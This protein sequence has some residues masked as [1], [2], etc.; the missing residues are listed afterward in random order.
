MF[1]MCKYLVYLK[2]KS[3]S[4]SK[5]DIYRHFEGEWID[6]TLGVRISHS[7]SQCYFCCSQVNVME[8]LG[9]SHLG[10]NWQVW[11]ENRWT[12]DR[13]NKWNQWT[14]KKKTE[15]F[16]AF[17][18]SFSKVKYYIASTNTSIWR[19]LTQSVL[20]VYVAEKRNQSLVEL[21]TIGTCMELLTGDQ[22]DIVLFWGNK[23]KLSV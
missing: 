19:I 2:E 8:W 14:E 23:S 18:R 15:D 16:Y 7:D 21:V 1:C 5:A 4:S 6:M 22:V 11:R 3:N 12:N 9:K 17:L 20:F 13:T 10:E